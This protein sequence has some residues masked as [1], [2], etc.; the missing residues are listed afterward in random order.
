MIVVI[1]F[2]TLKCYR[3]D[4]P[5]TMQLYHGSPIIVGRPSMGLGSRDRDFG[6]GFYCTSSQE[7][8][9]EWAC[10]LGAPGF[11]N[12]YVLETKGLKVLDLKR[13]DHPIMNWL[14]LLASNRSFRTESESGLR[15]LRYL[16]A[17]F[18]VD[19]SRYDVIKGPRGDDSYFSFASDF[20]NNT[21]S[22]SRLVSSMDLGKDG[23]QTVLVSERALSQL[24]Y[25]G[26]EPVDPDSCF[27]RRCERDI[28]AR[29][30]YL[31][32]EVREGIDEYDIM[33]DD[34]ISA[35]VGRDDPRL[36]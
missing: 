23:E 34:L 9:G 21:V 16:A 15:A 19:I 35:R 12:R 3:F 8:A 25:E 20:I 29:T 36:Q 1:K 11:V 6:R 2:I 5:K 26:S 33:I 24:H 30:R 18:P 17:E 32:R 14:S 7:I 28:R 13:T 10:P 4:M 22:F 31:G 27:R